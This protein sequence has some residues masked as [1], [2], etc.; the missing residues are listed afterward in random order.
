MRSAERLVR[1]EVHQ[2]GAEIAGAG[3]AQDGVHVRPVEIDQSARRVDPPGDL[4][5]L[6]LEHPQR[7]RVGDHHDGHLGV[8]LRGQVVQIDEPLRR[9]PHGHDAEAGHGGAGGVG[10]VGAVGDEHHAAALAAV[11]EVG[12]RDQQGGQLAVGARPPAAATRPPARKSLPACAAPG[13]AAPACP[14]ASLPADKDAGGG[15]P[16]GRPA[17]RSAWDCTSSYRSPADRSGYRPTC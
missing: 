6:R 3:D 11:A 7:V 17:A 9:A 14:A 1:V 12:G 16:A 10:A 8:E 15:S 5:D 2:V 13:R 4:G